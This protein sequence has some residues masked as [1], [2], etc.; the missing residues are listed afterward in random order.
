MNVGFHVTINGKDRYRVA[1]QEATRFGLTAIQIFTKSPRTWSSRDVTQ[2]EAEQFRHA[3]ANSP[4]QVTAAHASYLLNLGAGGTL[5]DKSLAGLHGELKN[6]SL[7]GLD[8]LVLH[9]GSGDLRTIRS[10][11]S[12]ILDEMPLRLKQPVQILIENTAGGGKRIGGEFE[13]LAYLID[14]L[15]LGVCFDTC[16]AFAAG[17]P[18]HQDPAGIMERLEN[19]VGLNR[20]PLLHLNDSA[21]ACASYRDKHANLLEGKIGETLKAWVQDPRFAGKTFIM[22][23]PRSAYATNLSIFNR[24]H[25]Q[26][27]MRT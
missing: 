8:Y 2:T 3:L 25:E 23:A 26:S 5:C 4:V 17:Y 6:A 13:D 9:P 27:S 18:L 11:L 22:E 21:Y 15:P 7:L 10:R 12:Q 14:G 20:I 1:L 24:W 19:S 16:H